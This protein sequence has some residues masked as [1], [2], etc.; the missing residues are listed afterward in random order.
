MEK[1]QVSSAN[2]RAS[3]ERERGRKVPTKKKRKRRDKRH[4]VVAA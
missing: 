3:G 2:M 4:G 1:E